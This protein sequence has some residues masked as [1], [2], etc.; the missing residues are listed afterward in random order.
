MCGIAGFF[1]E[2]LGKG[3]LIYFNESQRHRGPDA[4]GTFCEGKV[5]LSHTRLSIIDL[6]D[7][8]NQPMTSACQRYVIVYNGEIY[9]FRE[10]QQ[11]YGLNTSTSSDTEVLLEAF[12]I[13]GIEIVDELNG[14]F[15]F[16]IYDKT[17][18]ALW[19]CRDRLG[20][21]PLYYYWDGNSLVF[22]SELK[23]L[24]S[25]GFI[26]ERLKVN[27]MAIN[28]FLYLSF[29]PAPNSIYENIFKLEPGTYLTIKDGGNFVKH[30]YWSLNT[31]VRV[32]ADLSWEQAKAKLHQLLD[33]AVEK[34]MVSD[35]PLG[36][37][38]SGGIDSSIVTALA[39]AHSDKP[40]KTFTIGFSDEKF[41]EAPHAAAIASYLKTDHHETILSP[42][43][44]KTKI[45][46]ILDLYDEP[47]GDSSSIPTMLVSEVAR[48]QVKVILSGDGG[49]ECFLG[50]HRYIWAKRFER[51]TG[52]MNP[53]MISRILGV[54]RNEKW[55]RTAEIFNVR[56]KNEEISHLFSQNALQFSESQLHT[57]LDK[58]YRN[59]ISLWGGG[60]NGPG[61][62]SKA[63]QLA[64]FDL[65]YYLPDDNLTKV[66]RASMS[67][68]LEVRVPLLDHRVV[69]FAQQVPLPFKFKNGE[70]KRIL[71]SI[72]Y[73]RVPAHLFDR[74]KQGFSIPLN[75]WLKGD[76]NYLIK[77]FLSEEALR[78]SG[79]FNV[80]EILRFI[81]GFEKGHHSY[82]NKIWSVILLQKWYFEIYLPL[83]NG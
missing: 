16:A 73:D 1:A 60:W 77:E 59:A 32:N 44:A 31:N 10:V 65:T 5:G 4:S 61:K 34:Q 37:F 3:E 14:M 11:K 55:K 24:T 56:N 7:S 23:G 78:T 74:P 47:F 72:L 49:D 75:S 66:D 22:S 26:R 58:K 13:K 54:V 41:N 18:R 48:R 68:S 69:E 80:P 29:I 70:G 81:E 57:V 39:Q 38:L 71:K 25:I 76:L 20:V 82:V 79:F 17:E 51:M 42:D 15:A 43:E 50:Y 40:L 28:Q 83:T 35:V 33:S 62:L 46:N 63:E 53:Q 21:K 67:T 12:A 64:L 45:V 9:N 36:T 8:A 2:E 19:L 52:L 6:S 30:K 27:A